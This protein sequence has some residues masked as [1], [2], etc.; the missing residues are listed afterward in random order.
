MNK[1]RNTYPHILKNYLSMKPAINSIETDPDTTFTPI[2][3]FSPADI[4]LFGQVD[5]SRGETFDFFGSVYSDEFKIN[6]ISFFESLG[7]NNKMSKSLFK[8]LVAK[9]V[10]PFLVATSKDCIWMTIRVSIPVETYLIPR[11]HFDGPFYDTVDSYQLKLAG[12][13]IGPGTL[14]KKT[15]HLDV[16]NFVNEYRKLYSDFKREDY[17][18][19]KDIANRQLLD[20][21]VKNLETVQLTNDQIGIFTV[22]KIPK[23]AIH[24]EPNIDTPRLFFSVVSGSATNIKELA[25][26]WNEKFVD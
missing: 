4:D 9:A 1:S 23:V 2:K 3:V 13:L 21:Y 7:N 22:G 16:A 15:N 8:I 19:E 10:I 25:T 17:G 20:E 26:R 11:W 18:G 6:M 14:F 5:L 24:S 12:T